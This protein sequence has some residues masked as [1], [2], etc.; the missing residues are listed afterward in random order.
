MKEL[1]EVKGERGWKEGRVAKDLVLGAR[2]Q[3]FSP[4]AL[5]EHIAHNL[6]D[7]NQH[8]FLW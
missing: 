2:Y 5:L 6:V 4:L 3:I 1:W 7:P 8:L